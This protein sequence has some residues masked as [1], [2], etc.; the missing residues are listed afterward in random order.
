M[1]HP[2]ITSACVLAVNLL[3]AGGIY[4]ADATDGSTAAQA[5][6][7]ERSSKADKPLFKDEELDQMLAP[8]ALYPDPLLSQVFIAATY[9][10]EVVQAARWQKANEKLTGEKL[11]AALEKQSWDPSVK[12]MVQ[13][14]SVLQMMSDKLE[15]TQ[16]LGDAFLAQQP[17]VMASVQKLRK[18]ALDA[19]NLKDS[20]QQKIISENSQTT[21]IIR[22]E[23]TN[24]QVVYVPVYSTT[25]VY[26][27]WWYPGYPPYGYYPMGYYPYYP[28]TGFYYGAAWGLTV[29]WV[30][31]ANWNH[32]QLYVN[33]NYTRINNINI[34]GSGNKVQTLDQ[35]GQ[36]TWQHD[37]EHRKSVP[38]ADRATQ[39][40][41]E[42]AAANAAT[43]QQDYRGYDNAARPANSMNSVSPAARDQLQD[44]A[45]SM[46][47]EQRAAAQE[48]IGSAAPE[49]RAN[50]QDRAAS[51]SP[52][53][54]AAAQDRLGASPA[55]NNLQQQ[56]ANPGMP[57]MSDPYAS[58][59]SMDSRPA[60]DNY[61]SQAQHGGAFDSM[62]SGAS[63][64][65]DSARGAGSRMSA[66]GGAGARMGGGMRGGRR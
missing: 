38:Y 27:S 10:L 58:R 42:P 18:K 65:M 48:R 56:R 24:P 46:T 29:G 60:M 52:A 26:G 25:W 63:A 11:T 13:I 41:F 17:Q 33:N 20:E 47:P 28:A 4:A 49:A 32:A 40:K 64:R 50:L 66:G 45:A 51:M 22:I 19:G 53:E 6:A 8:I 55:Y 21:Q 5:A 3:L 15:W 14:P 57:P 9:P 61:R 1:K 35:N 36:R 54:R 44:R 62:G 16:K 39:S 59:Q 30:A 23:Q 34:Q 2:F 43:R 7:S 31:G 37:P 12:A